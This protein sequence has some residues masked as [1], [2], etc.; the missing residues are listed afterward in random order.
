[1]TL[2]HYG[3]SYN[4]FVVHPYTDRTL[5]RYMYQGQT[6]NYPQ[7]YMYIRLN[8]AY[9]YKYK[10]QVYLVTLS[11]LSQLLGLVYSR[12]SLFL[13]SLLL[14]IYSFPSARRFPPAPS[15]IFGFPSWIVRTQLLLLRFTLVPPGNIEHAMP[16][17]P[18]PQTFHGLPTTTSIHFLKLQPSHTESLHIA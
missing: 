14:N 1:M 17:V 16:H 4:R 9:K 5:Y 8:V 6:Q 11:S 3:I 12:S 18:Q 13:C 7:T 10:F 15:L 2:T